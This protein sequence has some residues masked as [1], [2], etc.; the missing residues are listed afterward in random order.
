MSAAR[1]GRTPVPSC[2]T[3]CAF[4]CARG[5]SVLLDSTRRPYFS[6][7]PR[8][9]R[10][11]ALVSPLS[12]GTNCVVAV[13]SV[14]M[15]GA[16]SGRGLPYSPNHAAMLVISG[17]GTDFGAWPCFLPQPTGRS[18]GWGR[19]WLGSNGSVSMAVFQWWRVCPSAGFHWCMLR[20]LASA[21]SAVMAARSLALSEAERTATFAASYLQ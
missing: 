9:I 7:R 20:A 3:L 12:P 2:R 4:S 17:A 13:N 11:A 21:P 19:A 16:T 5:L 18:T 1:T 8:I 15:P 6:T 14:R 10:T